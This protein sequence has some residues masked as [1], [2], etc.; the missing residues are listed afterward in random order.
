MS[1]SPTAPTLP[2]AAELGDAGKATLAKERAKAREATKALNAAMA[3][4]EQ[5]KAQTMSDG[6]K[7]IAAARAEAAAETAAKYGTRLATSAIKAAAAG[8][9]I[10]VE[11]LLKSVDASKFLD[12]DGEPDE[13]A[14]TEWLD[15]LAP[16]GTRPPP[17]L[18]Q[19]VRAPASTELTPAE[20]AERISANRHYLARG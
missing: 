9:P 15:E 17:D 5:L 11:A 8:R 16:V 20:A 2:P 4:L 1:T 18:G 14:I 6:D 7:A 13:A 19:G 12:D 10:N 3:E